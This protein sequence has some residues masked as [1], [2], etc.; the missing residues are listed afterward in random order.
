[1]FEACEPVS[2]QQANVQLGRA[3]RRGDLD[4]V[5]TVFASLA[6]AIHMR[7]RSRFVI[8]GVGGDVQSV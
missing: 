8:V 6:L 5:R 3:A 7:F 4:L 1:M 2:K